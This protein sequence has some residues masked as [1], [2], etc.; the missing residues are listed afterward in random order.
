MSFSAPD[1]ATDQLN[2]LSQI[3]KDPEALQSRIAQYLQVKAE[4]EE[5]LALLAHAE[6]I[7]ALKKAALDELEKVRATQAKA[8][9]VVSDAQTKANALLS[10][11]TAS[12]EGAKVQAAAMLSDAQRVVEDAQHRAQ[13]ITAE[14]TAVLN[15]ANAK[16]DEVTDTLAKAAAELVQANAAHA[17]ADAAAQDA[18][19]SKARHDDIVAR[20]QAVLGSA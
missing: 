10:D 17:L 12:L 16:L 3:L 20:L 4:S 15:T 14:A 18:A 1:P 11:A 19:D 6:Q 8:D 9:E 7:P 5:K 2:L 13:G